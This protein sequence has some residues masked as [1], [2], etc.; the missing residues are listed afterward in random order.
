[1]NKVLQD[2]LCNYL[3]F[4]MNRH[5]SANDWVEKNEVAKKMNAIYVLLDIDK[6]EDS[7]Y[8]E[9]QKN[10]QQIKSKL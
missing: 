7:W 4:L 5:A 9:I 1:M 10:I 6:H 3:G 2:E 8:E